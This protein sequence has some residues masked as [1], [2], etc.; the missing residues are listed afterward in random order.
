MDAK[1]QSLRQEYAELQEKLEH[2]DV[3]GRTDYPALARRQ[4]ELAKTIGLLDERRSLT[5]QMDEA[6]KLADSGDAELAEMA[7]SELEELKQKLAQNEQALNEFL[8]PKDP[9]DE[10]D[11]IVEI[12]A[13]AGGDESSLFAGELYRMYSRLL[14]RKGLKM[15]LVNESPSE[16]GGFK[17][18]VFEVRGEGAY[19]L[20]KFEA[21][22]HRVQR[23]PVTESQGRISSASTVFVKSIIWLPS[24]LLW[25]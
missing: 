11:C 9:S 17:E 22:V 15:E 14:E 8:L 7:K 1:E 10:R 16:A 18:I 13:A 25:M 20:L 4:G 21:G 5:Q 12:R 23:I 3:F 24:R 19:K 6:S 2:P